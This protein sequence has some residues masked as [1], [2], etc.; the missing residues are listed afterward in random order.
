VAAEANIG[1][2]DNAATAAATRIWDFINTP[3]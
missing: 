2:T 3:G 1:A